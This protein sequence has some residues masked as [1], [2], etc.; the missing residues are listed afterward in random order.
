MSAHVRATMTGLQLRRSLLRLVAAVGAVASL[1]LLTDNTADKPFFR[2]LEGGDFAIVDSI[3][4]NGEP[5]VPVRLEILNGV[6]DRFYITEAAV[7]FSGKKKERMFKDINAHLFEPYKEKITW[8][9]LT[10]STDELESDDAWQKESMIRCAA[11]SSM[12]KDAEMGILPQKFVV[13]NTDADEIPNPKV[14]EEFRPGKKWHSIVT[15]KPAFLGMSLF[16]YNLNWKAAGSWNKGHVLP[17]QDVISGKHNLQSFR[18][19]GDAPTI[20]NAGWHISYAM[21]AKEIIHKVEGFSHQEF[22]LPQFKSEDLIMDSMT[23]GVFFLT[24]EIF[25]HHDYKQV[26]L[27]LQKFHEE[28]CK[29]Q[30]VSHATGKRLELQ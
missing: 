30:S 9:P 26:P 21:P 3:M 5:I 10:F 18:D 13:L 6:V 14:V 28:V 29:S 23:D 12:K 4:Y 19:G 24:K 25:E 27:P 20:E 8:V 1:L 7:T 15:E 11:T 16:Y 2:S 17:G 22:N